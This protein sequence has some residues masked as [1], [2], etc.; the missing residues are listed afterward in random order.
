MP[1]Y[2]P[3]CSSIKDENEFHRN[4]ANKD[5]LSSY[6]IV[7]RKGKRNKAAEAAAN[8]KWRRNNPKQVLVLAA[9]S[10]AKRAGIPF[11]I[12]T[13]DF[14]IPESCPVLGLRLVAA[15]KRHDGSP[16]LDRINN[17]SGYTKGNVVVIS[18]RANRIKSDATLAELQKIVKFYE[19]IGNA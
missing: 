14:S 12:S 16:T 2:C 1:K 3:A 17:N 4:R 9:A 6:C 7:C 13:E 11:S 10:R 5:G 18:W 8:K 15:N 19:E